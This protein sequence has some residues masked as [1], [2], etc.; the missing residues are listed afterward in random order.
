MRQRARGKVLQSLEH[1]CRNATCSRNTDRQA[2]QDFLPKRFGRSM[3]GASHQR[4][5]RHD[6]LESTVTQLHGHC[7]ETCEATARFYFI[8]RNRLC[9]WSASAL[10]SLIDQRR[11]LT[12][13]V[14]AILLEEHFW[15]IRRPR[16][17]GPSPPTCMTWSRHITKDGTTAECIM[18][19]TSHPRMAVLVI[20]W[21]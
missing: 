21:R 10:A 11:Q 1:R 4:T 16:S 3:P 8:Q 18:N 6:R 13:C 15:T 12:R 5:F 2:M 7:A 19:H 17:A 20:R 9:Y 14:L